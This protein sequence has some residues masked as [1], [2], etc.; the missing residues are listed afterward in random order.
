MGDVMS[1][2]RLQPARSGFGFSLAL[3]TA[4]AV[5]AAGPVRADS[6]LTV[7][8][9]FDQGRT[10]AEGVFPET[11]P[12]IG[13]DGALY[14]T[15]NEGGDEACEECGTVYALT[16]N[17]QGQPVK[18]EVIH[19]FAG[20]TKNDGEF[21]SGPLT[22]DADGNLFGVTEGGGS[23]CEGVNTFFGCGVAFEEIPP[24]VKGDT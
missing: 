1:R 7:L 12:I 23:A 2:N 18:F 13:P 14:G 10:Y 24:P 17:K 21:P 15:A 8:H 6:P 20:G 19:V 5:L 4:L 16:P 9:T 22:L 3:A 11:A